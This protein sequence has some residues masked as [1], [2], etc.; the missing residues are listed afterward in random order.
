MV[1]LPAGPD[2]T[3]RSVWAEPPAGGAELASVTLTV[4]PYMAARVY[5][6]IRESDG[7]V[8]ANGGFTPSRDRPL[9]IFPVSAWVGPG[10]RV[11]VDVST[12]DVTACEGWLTWA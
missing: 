9:R 2:G 6:V 12:W 5:R 7:E 8:I 1:T 10:D 4:E 11:R 3:W